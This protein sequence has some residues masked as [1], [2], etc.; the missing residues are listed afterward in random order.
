MFDLGIQAP[1]AGGKGMPKRQ[2]AVGFELQGATCLDLEPETPPVIYRRFNLSWGAK[3]ELPKLLRAILGREAAPGEKLSPAEWLRKPVTVTVEHVQ[4]TDGGTA[5][6]IA[7]VTRCTL[8]GLPELTAAPL[9]YPGTLLTELPMGTRRDRSGAASY[10]SRSA[11][12][13]WL[14]W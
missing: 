12:R 7:G 11:G 13:E 4:R 8:K 6:R 9:L 10:C 5:A 14:R 1:P 3:A 2:L